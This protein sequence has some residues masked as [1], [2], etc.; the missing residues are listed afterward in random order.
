ME[1]LLEAAVLA[2]SS[3]NT[4]PWIFEVSDRRISL[5]ADRTRA[6]PV[7]DPDDR[8]LTISCGAALFNLRVAA[9]GTRLGS[10]VRLLPDPDHND[11]LAVVELDSG[12]PDQVA[13]LHSEIPRRRTYRKRFAAKPVPDSLLIELAGAAEHEGAWL[14]VLA[15]EDQ[16]QQAAKLV[17]EGDAIQWAD[18]SWRRELAAWM[19]PRRKGD[20]LT[21]PGFVAPIAQTVVRTFDM[22][23]G[24][25]AKDS[26]LAEESPV[27]AVL[28]TSGDSQ[29]DWL[30]AGQALER[31]LLLACKA[32]VQASYLNQPIQTASLRPKLQHAIGAAGFPQ[33]LLRLG[34]PIGDL[35]AAP[36][37]SL[38]AVVEA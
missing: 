1:A 17:A 5:L 9:A 2:P 38:E 12:S 18:R 4:Q 16:R 14:S 21:V 23:N 22:G 11:L 27:L 8:E 28:G 6:L 29:A 37:R 35:P 32:G 15:G 20:G 10:K 7:N 3:H 24:V 33:I 26:Q 25:G 19:H 31:L 13:E 34:F 36:R 30:M